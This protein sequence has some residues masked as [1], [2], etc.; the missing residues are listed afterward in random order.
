MDVSRTAKEEVVEQ[1]GYH[2]Q[3]SG[4]RQRSNN[5]AAH[6]R[7]AGVRRLPEVRRT[8]G[9]PDA[10]RELHRLALLDTTLLEI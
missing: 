1:R 6:A 2:V 8:G 7:I 10:L 4:H 5:I 9:S 3:H